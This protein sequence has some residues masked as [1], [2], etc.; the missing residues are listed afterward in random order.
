MHQTART[1]G[2][3]REGGG[4]GGV[5]RRAEH[6]CLH[7]RDAQ[8]HPR[9]DIG[10][11]RLGGCAIYQCI[12]IDQMATGFRRDGDSERTV[13]RGEQPRGVAGNRIHRFPPA[14][15]GI[16]QFQRRS[17]RTKAGHI[18]I[19]RDRGFGRRT[20]GRGGWSE[21]HALALE[22][23]GHLSNGGCIGIHGM[24]G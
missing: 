19:I 5:R 16:E 18:P 12:E 24:I 7:Q 9:L 1:T 11:E 23:R 22:R 13:R 3:E 8:H 15:D 10:R 4:D 14:Q 6:Q 17:A 20:A 2:D 21:T